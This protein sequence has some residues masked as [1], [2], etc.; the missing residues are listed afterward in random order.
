[1]VLIGDSTVATYSSGSKQGWGYAL[2]QFFNSSQ[3]RIVNRALGGRSSETYYREGHWHQ[4]LASK[5]HYVFIQ[6]GHND[7]HR[8]DSKYTDP[9]REYKSYLRDYIDESR[10]QGAIPILVTP[11]V[12]L[13]W[14]GTK[15]RHTLTA[16]VRSMKQVGAEMKVPV[17]DLDARSARFYESLGDTKAQRLFVSNDTTHTNRDGARELARLLVDEID[18]KVPGL[19]RH[20]K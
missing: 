15:I 20:L 8:G 4:A 14:S 11:P 3:V 1:M 16:Y 6:F 7:S 9:N 5:P 19:A 2:P 12:R 17:L 13:K 10:K 18:R